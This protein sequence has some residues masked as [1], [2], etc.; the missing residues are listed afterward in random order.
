MKT[1]SLTMFAAALLLLAAPFVRA[2]NFLE[3]GR[4]SGNFQ[5]DAQVY[6]ADSAIGA[7]EVAEKMRMNSFANLLYTNGNFSAGLR[8]ESYLNPI[9][10]YDPRYKGNGV[11]YWFGSWRNEQFEITVGNFYE[12]FG[13]GMV[14]RSYEERNLGYDNALKGAKVR[15]SPTE[16][17]V[18]KGLIGTQRYF[19]EQGPGIVRGLDGEFA[20]NDI[21]DKEAKYRTRVTLGGSFVSKYQDTE[22]IS[23]GPDE[24]LILPA[25]VASWAARFNISRGGF[26]ID[27]EYANKMNDPS[28][29]NDYIYKN[30]ESML[31]QTSYS[32]RGL[33]VIVSAKR[34]DNMSFK[35]KRTETGSALDINYL[36]ALTRQHAYALSAM[37]PYATQPNGEMAL[38]GQVNYK[39]KRGSK[40]GGKYG[41]DIAINYS[42]ITSIQRD[43]L[44]GDTV[45][46]GAGTA[47]YTSPFLAFGNELY[48][49]DF[50]IEIQRKFTADF[51]L[52]V[53][54]VNLK[55]NIDVI[56]GHP[57]DPMVNAHI[58]IADG[59]YRL[60]DKRAVKL[61]YQHLLTK[62]DEGDW[63]QF[64][65]EYTVAPKWYL[66]VADQYNYGN[67]D[68]DRRFH[69]PAVSAGYT[70]GSN[71][72]TL[73]YGKQ[74][75]GIL[76]VGGV[77][78][79]VPASNGLTIT[80]TSAF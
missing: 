39:I 27:G 62:E 56:E 64:L 61:E 36:P 50:N 14:L 1:T 26:A 5:L 21:F 9:L 28:A 22:E 79:N 38:Q 4:V 7:F 30:G 66:T 63:L 45:P 75:E 76:C 73:T 68:K 25:N 54:Y 51:K 6:R 40:I 58:F 19:W 78:R 42:R 77:C 34:T 60:T 32:T 17:V 31:L 24:L 55:Y 57:G 11:P 72:L 23:A 74:R 3:G 37:Y 15:F 49:R 69:Y 53:S 20:L 46:G 41:T 80:L 65:I 13:S 35:S 52:L 10:G 67:Q 43:P 8:A 33:G 29:M 47:G 48:F 12:Q 18:L 16:G 71:R 2:Q 59:T 44:E 70:Y